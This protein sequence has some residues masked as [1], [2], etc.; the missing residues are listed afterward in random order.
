EHLGALLV[1]D[2]D[3]A[4]AAFGVGELEHVRTGRQGHAWHLYRSAEGE[5]GLLRVLVRARAGHH[6]HGG[7]GEGATHRDEDSC[8][9]HWVHSLMDDVSSH[10][11]NCTLVTDRRQRQ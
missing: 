8:C 6:E 10:S 3:G 2:L 5:K 4:P 11:R 9:T 7:D 1:P